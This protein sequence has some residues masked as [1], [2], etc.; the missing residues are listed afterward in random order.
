MGLT[1]SPTIKIFDLKN[2]PM[3]QEENYVFLIFFDNHHSD[4][5]DI[6]TPTPVVTRNF[7]SVLGDMCSAVQIRLVTTLEVTSNLLP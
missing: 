5:I 2:S 3:E 6:T 7:A 1:F 4:M